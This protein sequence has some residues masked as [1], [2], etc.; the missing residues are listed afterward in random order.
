MN[1]VSDTPNK[2]NHY[3]AKIYKL[4]KHGCDLVVTY[5]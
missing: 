3:R 1:P 4:F 5:H 2:E